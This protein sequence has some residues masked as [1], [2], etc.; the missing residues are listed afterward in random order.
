M[1]DLS[2]SRSGGTSSNDEAVEQQAARSAAIATMFRNRRHVSVEDTISMHS[3]FG[4]RPS[5][6]TAPVPVPVP[7]VKTNKHQF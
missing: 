4:I 1:I 5:T 7:E 3:E 6:P 2:Y